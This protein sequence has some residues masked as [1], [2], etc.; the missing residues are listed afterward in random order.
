MLHQ[1]LQLIIRVIF[2]KNAANEYYMY[3]NLL[4]WYKLLCKKVIQKED[5]FESTI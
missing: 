1:N 3:A 5:S 4:K 2:I